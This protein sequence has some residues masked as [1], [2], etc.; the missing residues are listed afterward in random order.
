MLDRITYAHTVLKTRTADGKVRLLQA[1]D[2]VRQGNPDQ[3]F[4]FSDC[5]VL[6]FSDP[7]K[8]KGDVYVKLGRPFAYASCIGTTGPSVLTGVEE[9]E[10]TLKYLLSMVTVSE[11]PRVSSGPAPIERGFDSE[12]ID[13]SVPA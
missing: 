4:A 8:N 1:G 13:I 9:F 6:G 3:R 5:I 2:V 10:V 7:A 12:I 11:S